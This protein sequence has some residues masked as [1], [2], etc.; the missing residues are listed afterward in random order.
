MSLGKLL[1][2]GKSLVGLHDANARYRLR[3][4]ALPKFESPKNPFARRQNAQRKLTPDE[5]AA[6]NL[7]KT[8]LL[9]LL[10]VKV[11][12]SSAPEMSPLSP[13]RSGGETVQE[14]QKQKVVSATMNREV[15]QPVKEAANVK[16]ASPIV[17][18]WL[19]KLNPMVWLGN[20]KTAEPKKSA[21]PRFGKAPV[22]GE[23]S[24]DNI[25][26]MRNDL[27][28]ADVEV[29][30]MKARPAK[31]VSP[32]PTPTAA[33]EPAAAA[34]AIP[35]LPPPTNAWEFLGERLLGKH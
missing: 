29:V 12:Q 6:A 17:G 27:S 5:I 15:S 32:A 23:L 24:L 31:K 8:Q 3:E 11:S 4:G 22:Q 34:M 19:K 7:K 1:T 16:P 9:P 28:E 20:R 21:I 25:K 10:P 26:V 33:P 30:P 18:S 2:T 13:P 35:E 14:E